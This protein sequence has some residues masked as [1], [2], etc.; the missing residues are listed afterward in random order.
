VVAEQELRPETSP[1]GGNV[2]EE[3][4]APEPGATSPVAVASRGPAVLPQSRAEALQQLERIAEFFRRTEPHSPVA[5]L[6]ERAVRWGN[7][8]LD[9]WL[10]QVIKDPGVLSSLNEILGLPS[11]TE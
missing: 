11:Q 6:L 1:E 3:A 4:S 8:P 5:Y 2:I 10:Q 9:L 7:M